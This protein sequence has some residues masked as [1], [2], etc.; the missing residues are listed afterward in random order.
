[1]KN[2]AIDKST[3]SSSSTAIDK[4]KFIDKKRWIYG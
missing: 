1:M 3:T 2:K 4:D